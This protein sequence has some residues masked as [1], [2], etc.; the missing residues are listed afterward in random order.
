MI[1]AIRTDH[2]ERVQN[3]IPRARARARRAPLRRIQAEV[4]P[5]EPVL[6]QRRAVQQRRR[7][8]AMLGRNATPRRSRAR[9][10]SSTCCSGRP[11]RASRWSTATAVA[12]AEHHG[13][14]VPCAFNRKEAKD[15][16]EGG[17]I[18][19]A[20]LAGRVLIVD[21]VITAGTA[22]REV[23]GHHP[24]GR[25]HAGGRARSRSTARKRG[26]RRTSRPCRKLETELGSADASASLTLA[27]LIDHLEARTRIR[28]STLPGG[29]GVSRTATACLRESLACPARAESYC[30]RNSR[31]CGFHAPVLGR[32]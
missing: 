11:T 12:L 19:G 9:A 15:H 16:G 22:I 10:S 26:R 32:C 5:R 29:P 28:C 30:G 7:R 31:A 2:D 13:R 23:G 1:P 24:R 4:R 6:L 8:I 17:T 18:V 20:P 21:D 14:D 25:R 3:G 27:D